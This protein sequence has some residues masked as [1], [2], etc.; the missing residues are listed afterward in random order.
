MSNTAENCS[1]DCGSCT[2]NCSSRQGA[3]QQMNKADFIE[4]LD[5][6]SS[7]KKVIGIVSGKGGVGKSMV[8]S[9][10]AC[11]MRAKGYRVGILDADLTGPSIP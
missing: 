2:A 10:M 8:T 4:K 11:Q 9:L 3:G 1:H 5:P 7:V 6:R